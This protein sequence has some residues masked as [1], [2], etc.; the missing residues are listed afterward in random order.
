M[1]SMTSNPT[2]MRSTSQDLHVYPDEDRG[3]GWLFFAGSILGLAGIMRIIDSI[4]AFTYKGALPD[5]LRD[6]VLG[7]NLKTYAWV[8]LVIGALLIVASFM[9]IARSQ[10]ARWFG[11]I[12]AGL[13]AI[14]AITWMPYY[15]VWS[16]VYIGLAVGAIYGLS[17]YGGRQVS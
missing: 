14:S 2:G 11:I 8:W 5:N 9:V 3:F 15:P 7:D 6:G 1:S 17:V 13:A 10:F 4:W 16:L 12:A